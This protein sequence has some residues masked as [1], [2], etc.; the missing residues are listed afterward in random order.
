MPGTGADLG[1]R[2]KAALVA[3]AGQG[4]GAATALALAAAGAS[5]VCADIVLARA[6]EVAARIAASGGT[7][8]ALDGDVRDRPAVESMVAATVREFGGVDLV[9]DIVG[10]NTVKP[11]IET[12]DEEWDA[13]Q[14]LVVRPLFLLA[15]CAAAQMIAQGHGGAFVSISSVS[16]LFSADHHGAYGAAKAA[17]ISLT[18]TLAVELAPYGIRVNSVA[19]GLTVTPRMAVKVERDPGWLREVEAAIPMGRAATPD[20]IAGAVVLLLSDLAR[21]CTG[22][23]L[24]VDGG[25]SVKF[26]Y[27]PARS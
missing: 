4:I 17:M 8:V 27:P 1:L 13:I 26:P 2:A 7:A 14:Q 19:P 16:G 18:K 6:Q 10:Q 25:A 21:Y 3:G 22:Q 15:Q 23:T 12:T 11:L 20:D 24:V 5:V 9:V